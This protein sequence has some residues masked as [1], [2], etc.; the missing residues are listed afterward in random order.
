MTNQSTVS[1]NIVQG[2]PDANEAK[3]FAE[4]GDM[5][6][7]GLFA[8]MLGAVS[9]RLM[10]RMYM[11]PENEM[12]FQ[13]T[14][15]AYIDGKIAGMCNGYSAAQKQQSSSRSNRLMLQYARW[16]VVRM[17]WSYIR[18]RHIVDFAQQLP[19]DTFYIQMLATYSQFRGHG[20]GRQL[21]AHAAAQAAAHNCHTLAQDVDI[22]NT[23]AIR[24][25]EYTGFTVAGR[26]P[27]KT[28]YGRPIGMQR[29]VKQVTT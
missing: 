22:T 16:R 17:I 18:L 11:Q 13:Q 1:I 8:H 12:S 10:Q 15:F 29:M 14:H 24:V 20:I 26:S 9:A 27:V 5:A 2:T 21:L 4:L 23:N 19:D 7:G 28:R 25:Y 3:A 6:A